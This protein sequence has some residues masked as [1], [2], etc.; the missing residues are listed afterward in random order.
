MPD[1]FVPRSGRTER[2]VLQRV[3]PAGP[4]GSELL[5]W[6]SRNEPPGPPRLS[7]DTYINLFH[8]SRWRHLTGLTDFALELSG[9]GPGL[10]RLFSLSGSGGVPAPCGARR[11]GRESPRAFL[12][13]KQ[14]ADFFFFDWTPDDDRAAP[15]SAEYT[16]ERRPGPAAGPRLALVVTTFE[17]EADVRLTA[18]SYARAR[19]D[20]LEIRDL[21]HLYVVNNQAADAA[22]LAGLAAEGIT[23]I[24]NPRN[25]GG[26]GGFDRGAREAVAAGI[27]SHVLFMDDDIVV[28]AEA[29][30][31]SLALLANLKP[32]YAAQVVGGGMFVRERPTRCH[33][34]LEGL[35]KRALPQMVAGR[36]DLAD[37][38]GVLDLLNLSDP[39]FGRPDSP[40][41]PPEAPI[42]PYA[43][44]WYC[45]I[46][47]RNF[48]EHGY[49]L[50][51]FF[52]GDDQEFG[53]RIGRKVLSLN[54][55]CVWHPDFE[56]LGKKSPLRVYLGFRNQAI[57]S[58]LH[59]KHWRLYAGLRFLRS[60]PRLLAAN[61]YEGAA[62]VLRAFADYQVFGRIQGDGPEILARLAE[63]RAAWPNT[64]LEESRAG[65]PLKIPLKK[66]GRL[67]P[68]AAVWLTL[69]GGL[70]PGPL[71]HRGPILADLLQIR[72]K[73]PARLVAYPEDPSIK[74]FKRALA[75]RLSLA[76]IGRF[77][78]FLVT[79][80]RI[81]RELRSLLAS[82]KSGDERPKQ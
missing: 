46:P 4:D 10:V 21:T 37:L 41:I 57:Y 5:Y 38:A 62:V 27:Y 7:T 2:Q 11:L 31:R 80:N 45:V 32:R 44:W 25:T 61:D 73:F 49:P 43:A 16:A 67:W 18:D 22:K 42:R 52:R 66:K 54:G 71:F 8:Q 20:Y 1:F 65:P 68:L 76:G 33:A 6:R 81:A 74:A 28:Q 63:G 72:G 53:V 13:L 29:W 26:A 70:I 24:N 47:I 3:V 75:I 50:P 34:L 48:R 12:P 58:T 17:R 69:G 30:L 77:F 36:R 23:L 19:R 14:E 78:T 64:V 79:G 40:T 82:V 9:N 60:F 51:V 56:T 55:I 39:D 35:N 15:P 59:F